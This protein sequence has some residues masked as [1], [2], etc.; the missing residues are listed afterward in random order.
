MMRHTELP[1]K[2]GLYDPQFEKDACG[3]GF[4]AHIKGKPSHDIVSNALTM[5]FNMEHRGGQGSEP[6]SGD[7]AGIMLQIPHRFFAGEAS[8]LGF[9]LPEQGQYGVGMIFLSHNEEIRARHEALLSEIIAEEGQVVLGYRDVPTYDEMLGKTAK[10]AKPYVRQVFIGRSE[11]LADELAFERK[12]FVI[13]KRAELAIRYGGVEEAESF[14]MPS[15]SC[16]K[17]VY[18]GMLTTEQVGQFYLDLQNEDLESAIALVHSRF[19]TNTFPSWERAHPYRFM[20]HNGEINTLR[21]NVNW[22]HARQSLFKSEVFGESL[23]KIKPIVNPDGSDTAMFDNTFEFLY[24]SG[25]SLPHV[26]MMMVPE[27]WS[28]HETMS[29]EK[30]AFYEYHSTLMEPWDGP[31]AM[32]FTDGVQIGAMLDRNGLRPARYYVTKDDMIIL[33]S[34]AGVLDIPAEDVLYKDRLRPGRML[35]VDTKQGRIISDEEV[36]A[37]IASEQPYRQWLDEHLIGLDQLPEAPELPNPKHDNVQQLQQSFGYTFEDLRKVLEPMASTGAEAVGSMGYDAPLAVLSD[38]P[39]RL[40]NYFKQMFAQVTNPPIDAIREE[41]VTSTATTIGPERNLLKPEPESCRQISLESPILSNEDFAKIRHVRRAGFKSMSIPILF[42][43]ELGAEGMRIAL[44]RMNEAADRVMAKGHNILILSDRGVDRENAAIPALLAVSSLHHHLIRSGSRTKVSILLESGEPREVHHYALLLGYGVSAVNPYLAFESLDDMIGQGLLRGISHEKAVKNYIKA[45]T[46]SVVKILSKMGI[47][48]IQSYRGAQIFEAVGLSAEFV[49][50]YFTWTPSRIG[51]IGLA[52]VAAEALMHHNRA[53]TDKDGNDKVLDSGGD[54]QWRS[55][56]E[57]HLFNPQTIHLLQH[58]VRSGDYALYKKYAALVQGE[59]K[60]HQTIRSMLEFKSVNQPVPLDEVESAESIMKRFKTGAM[61]F[62]SISKEAHE[63]LAIAMNRIGG[64]SNTGEGGEDPARFTPDANGD[65]RRSAIKQVASG[66]FGVTSNYLVNADEIQIKMAQGAK[67]G[68]GGQLPGRKVY[69]WVA[70]VRGSTAGVGLISPPPHHD[71]YS[72]EDLAELIYD[73]KNANPRASIN[74][75]LVSEVGVGTIAAGV[76]KGRADIILIS[77]YDGG[78]GA[79]PMNSIRHAGLPWELGLAE[80]HQTLMLNNLRDRVVLETDGKMLSGRDLAVAVL[81]GAEEYGFATAPLVAVGCIMMRVCQMDTCPVGVAT[82]NPDL[83]K[84]FTGDPQHVVNFMTFVAQDLREIMAELGFRTIE[85]MVGRT[86][87]LDAVHAD[88]HW[89]KKGVDLSGLLHT[90][91]LPEGSTRFRSKFQNHGLEETIDVSKLLDLAAP[92]L[93]S[94][95]PVEVS[96]P[97]TNVNRAVGTI[98]GSELTRKYGATGLPDDTIRLNFTGSAGQSL[99]AFVPKGIT[100]TVEG[101]SN[102]YVGKGLSGGKL[103]I[104]PSPKATFA[105][106]DNIIIGNTALYGATGGEAYI[107]GIAGERFA[108]RNSGA[109]VV[110]EGVGDHG[111]EYMTGGRVAVLGATG[112]NFAAGMSGGIAY[113]YDPENS[114]IK[115][116]NL[117]MVLLERVEEAEEAAELH[118]LISRHAELTGSAAAGRILGSWEASLPK[119]VRVIPKDYKR[120]LE[121]IRKVEQTGLTGE[122]ALMAAFEA[123]MRELARVGG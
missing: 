98:L 115:R 28:N 69:P 103:I 21:G 49:D 34:E 36:K 52:E 9:E 62:G 83:R 82:Q 41:L 63:T 7:G 2:Q 55:D 56:G 104:K 118:K 89:K 61:S 108:V 67:P 96:L 66:R 44:E 13:R 50:R 110:V 25:R 35:L 99:G 38:R 16:R 46:K 37:Q 91:E 10:A 4:V 93:E 79:S 76:A 26:A 100:I 112:R 14:Y 121:Q 116:C 18:K 3:M 5:L 94:G 24:L 40:Y 27:P 113:V 11:G 33:S 15:M 86:D 54:Y 105:A 68:E 1:N 74:V 77:G 47:S 48:T 43:A 19:S 109:N 29:D 53:F 6:N 72:I 57:D 123:N 88:Y 58:S 80:T 119:F 87:C 30:K 39:Q 22:M 31:A 45:A 23:G 81:L 42:P 65:S 20:I 78:T 17:I 101:D 51:G 60:K 102:D 70:E 97:I 84:N 95:Q 92:A 32:G 8:K 106:E 73:L 85:E 71:I 59:S 114:F 75:K 12:L 111:C 90:P 122:A 107:N 120:M 117:E 64:K